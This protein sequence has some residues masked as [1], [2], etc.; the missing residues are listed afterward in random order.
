MA[1]TRKLM[2]IAEEETV[3]PVRVDQ[4]RGEKTRRESAP[5]P[6]YAVDA[7]DVKGVVVA[8]PGLDERHRDKAENADE[9]ADHNRGEGADEAGCRRNGDK[10]GNRARTS[11]EDSRFPVEDPFDDGPSK[12]RCR[13]CR[14]RDDEGV[15]REAVCGKRASR[16]EAEPAEPEQGGPDHH[17]RQVVR[18]YA[19]AVV[20]LSLADK[21]RGREGADACVDVDDRAARQNRGRQ[22]P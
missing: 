10:T 17:V 3:A 19:P 11:A 7:E 15:H 13:G 5:D 14:V 20:A 6:A 8:E 9:Y 16:I 2:G 18:R 12:T 21:E 1:W 4:L 22:A